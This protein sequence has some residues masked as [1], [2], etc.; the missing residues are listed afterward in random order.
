MPADTITFSLTGG[1]DQAKFLINATTGDLTFSTAPD[2]EIPTGVGT[3]NV[4]E[5]QV[6]ANDGNGGVDVQLITVT[7]SPVNDNSPVFTNPAAV[8]INE[9]TT[10]VQTVTTTDADMPAQLVTYAISGGNAAGFFTINSSTGN[11]EFVAA[12]DFETAA[13][14]DADN[15]YEVQVTANDNAG[16]TTPQLITVS[17]NDVDDAPLTS[18][19]TPET[20]APSETDTETVDESTDDSEAEQPA[21]SIL[22][23]IVDAPTA[24][25]STGQKTTRTAQEET[26]AAAAAIGIVVLQDESQLESQILT[27]IVIDVA[28]SEHVS[29]STLADL[30]IRRDLNSKTVTEQLSPS[31]LASITSQHLAATFA[32]DSRTSIGLNTLKRDIF[33]QMSFDDAIVGSVATVGSGLTAGYILWAIR[34]GM[35]LSGLLAQM[36]VWTMIDPLLIVDRLGAPDSQGNRTSSRLVAV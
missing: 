13:D 22:A 21:E 1:A 26:V 9:K 29:A 18:A 36:P 34:G 32:A 31:D 4:Y 10:F 35:L 30:S 6:A 23:R 27:E 5:V 7:V 15:I 19:P 2:F 28:N 24:K 8:S 20:D 11:L 3:N 12:P 14:F 25:E 33:S 17:I 16:N